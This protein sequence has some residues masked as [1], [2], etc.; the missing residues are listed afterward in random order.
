LDGL[1]AK[2]LNVYDLKGKVYRFNYGKN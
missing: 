2:K 1:V